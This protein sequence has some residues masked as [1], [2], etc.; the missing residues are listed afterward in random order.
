[1]YS[2]NTVR[3]FIASTP[4]LYWWFP[5]YVELRTNGHITAFHLSSYHHFLS[6]LNFVFVFYFQGIYFES[7]C[8]CICIMFLTE[9]V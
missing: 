3:T 8:V 6:V 9:D 7:R 4:P 2:Q 1:M 5:K